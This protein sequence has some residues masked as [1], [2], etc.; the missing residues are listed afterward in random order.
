M[1][2]LASFVMRGR[3]QATLVVATSAVLSALLPPVSWLSSGAVALVTLR[4][5]IVDGLLVIVGA[6]VGAGILS[7]LALGNPWPAL[8]FALVLW[9]PVA[10]MAAVLR[11]TV[12]LGAAL[13]VAGVIGLLAVGLLHLLLGDPGPWW[14]A[15][16][17]PLIEPALEGV[18][19]GQAALVREFIGAAADYMTGL[20]VAAGLV[21]LLLGL[22]IGRL[23]QAG[24]YNPG[25]FRGEFHA[26]RLPRVAAVAALALF[27]AAL[28]QGGAPGLV[29]DL[30]AALLVPCALAG[31]ATV[32]GLAGR[33]RGGIGVLVALYV[34]LVLALPEIAVA[35]AAMGLASAWF[36]LV[37]R[38]PARP[39]KDDSKTD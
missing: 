33:L 39:G 26:L 4:K 15:M 3:G 9:L 13:A 34:M 21:N 25:G 28:L 38:L 17:Q 22:V 16:L 23:W 27:A 14:A 7:F 24:L 2:G 10:A 6:L 31:L 29:P 11:A 32:H 8:S 35:L 12:D 37:G 5:G 19:A 30:A 36:D 20:M 18:D 1:R